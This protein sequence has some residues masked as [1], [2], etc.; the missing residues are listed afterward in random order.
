MGRAADERAVVVGGG[1]AGLLAARVL[2]D[3]CVDVRV[4][5]RDDLARIDREP[6]LPGRDGEQEHR[7]GVLQGRH[8]HALLPRG[9]AILE[10]LFPGLTREL[11]DGGA[12]SGD[13]LANARLHLGG[14]RLARTHAGLPML[15]VS[16][17]YLERAIRDRVRSRPNVTFG[18]A[19]DVLGLVTS[20][21]GRRV[22]GVRLLRRAD[23][24]AEEVLDTG[25]VID[26]MGRGSRSPAWLEDLGYRPPAEERI[27]VDLGYATRHYRLPPDALDG[28]W[29]TLQGPTPALARGGALARIEGDRWIVTLFGYRGHHPPTA[30]EG[31]EDF[32]GTLPFPDLGRAIG[33]GEADDDPV[34]FR[35]PASVRRR[36]ERLAELPDGLLPLGDAVCSLNPI[37]G[38]GMTVAALQTLALRDH[39][40]HGGRPDP[41]RWMRAVAGI[42]DAPWNMV[43]AGDLAL[44]MVEGPRTPQVRVLGAYVAR[45]Q[46]AAA[47]DPRLAIAFGRVM[48]LVNPP[49]SLLRPGTAARVLVPRTRRHGTGPTVPAVSAAS[50]RTSTKT[51]PGSRE[52]RR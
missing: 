45:L 5:D 35:F 36:Y 25:L 34:A 2:A 24:S 43:V 27:V 28:D 41:P 1:M 26:A 12:P 44:P 11:V 6:L 13:M 31:F 52:V 49:T 22:T 17:P 8:I 38:Q 20:P 39:L 32:A 4:L 16:R 51:E 9:R 40:R 10:E 18:P 19:C 3:H 50:D 30:P 21:D 7:R 33:G 15:S 42:V 23:G 29:G 14:H 37:Y 48:S 47:H 46:T